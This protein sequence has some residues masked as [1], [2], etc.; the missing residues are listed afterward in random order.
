M[1]ARPLI[2]ARSVRQAALGYEAPQY[3]TRAE[4]SELSAGVVIAVYPVDHP[5][6]PMGQMLVDV[7]LNHGLPLLQRV[8]VGTF[9]VHQETAIATPRSSDRQPYTPKARNRIEG[10]VRDLRAGTKVLVG[11]V[12]ANLRAPVVVCALPFNLQDAGAFPVARQAVD[13][14]DDDGKL[15]AM[16]EV[17]SAH[18]LMSEYPRA[19][20]TY[21]GTR[22]ERDNRGNL[23]VQTTNDQESVF[24]GDNGIPA[25]PKPEGNIGFSTRGARRGIQGRITGEHPT[26]GETN[27]DGSIRDE[28]ANAKIGNL[29]ARLRSKV[30]RYYVSTRGSGD[31]RVYLE[32]DDRSYLALK[33]GAAEMHGDGKGVID[34]DDVR[35]GNASAPYEIVLWPQLN[36]LM[37]LLTQIFDAHGHTEVTSGSS[38]S[39]PPD[40]FQNAIWMARGDECKADHVKSVKD[41]GA[42]PSP[43]DDP[44]GE[45]GG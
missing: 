23:H 12:N 41:Q 40:A 16:T 21:N 33:G 11:F 10:C 22:L 34:A 8:P 25:A 2:P 9:Y 14:F 36:E 45:G 13:R 27:S 26:T 15:L 44:N 38:V 5:A 31:A 32:N 1:S 19:V 35:L 6:N 29:I 18:A 17:S 3:D 42:T 7:Q 20:D 30:G 37:D 39:G 4:I 28:T 43:Q 24:P